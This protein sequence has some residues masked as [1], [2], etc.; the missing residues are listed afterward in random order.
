MENSVFIKYRKP[1][2]GH[3]SLVLKMKPKVN[4]EAMKTGYIT[5]DITKAAGVPAGM[6]T[7]PNIGPSKE[8][9]LKGFDIPDIKDIEREKGE[10]EENLSRINIKY[11]LIP[12]NPKQGENIFAY[13]H[14]YFD[15]RLNE[16]VYRVVEPPLDNITLLQKIKDYVQEKLNVN[17]TQIRKRDAF[18]Y[19]E[20]MFEK[21]INFLG[22]K[23]SDPEKEILKYYLFRDFVGLEKIEPLLS[24]SRIEDISCDG[25]NIPIYVYHRDPRIGSIRT[26]VIFKGREKSDYFVT[27]LAERTGGTI[28]VAK[29]LLDGTL[30]DGSRVQATL[31][32]DIARHGSNFTIRMFT[33]SPLTPIHMLR[34][35]T[36]DLK[37]L[38]YFW[39]LVEHGSS[40][41]ISGGTAS[42]KTSLLNALSLFIK[43]QMKI[44]S[45]ED[46]SELRLTHAHW[47]PEVARTPISE[48]G[49]VDMFELLRESLRQ[50]PD[51]II[52]GEVRGK[53][54]Y[55]LFQQMAMGHPGMST[56]HAENFPKLMDRL[57]SPPIN[58]SASLIQN[59]DL[60]LFEKRIRRGRKYDRRVFS[61]MEI[62]G[63]DSEKKTPIT[64]EAFKHDPIKNSFI[65]EKSSLLRK[66]SE[67]LGIKKQDI[68]EEIQ[69]RAKILEWMHKKDISDY[70]K[71][72]SVINLYYLSPDFVMR[73][74]DTE[75]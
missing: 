63:F 2:G 66:F 27:K 19:M 74:I 44:V 43:P 5:N 54:A 18:S 22:A 32:S 71:F 29:P 38:A 31:G 25:V 68:L 59:L 70:R 67:S 39:L 62:M 56:I 14:I 46:T 47:V 12:K 57:S 11:P 75:L 33:E 24:D 26:N 58:L 3:R 6:T 51:Y 13:S 61:V 60:I 64:N 48:K 49:K 21:S 73:R 52:V 28:S 36:C 72:S 7:I 30:P 10:E 15:S 55:V 35:G 37:M 23:V 65:G 1:N 42:G 4:K 16:L 50:R 69:K 17:F 53:E 8:A 45:I 34:F 20:N 9:G 41:L 40:I